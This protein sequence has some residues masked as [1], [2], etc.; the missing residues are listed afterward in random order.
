MNWILQNFEPAAITAVI[1]ALAGGLIGFRI[2]ISKKQK[3]SQKAGDN[4]QQIQVGGNFS[5]NK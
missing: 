1:S 3:Q 5:Y 2:G 4:S